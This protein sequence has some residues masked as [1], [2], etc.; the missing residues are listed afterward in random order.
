MM[1]IYV[2]ANENIKYRQVVS[3]SMKNRVEWVDI[4]KFLGMFFVYLWHCGS[5]TGYIYPWIYCFGV[6]L[7]FFLAGCTETYNNRGVMQ[8]FVHMLKA[9][10]IPYLFFSFLDIVFYIVAYGVHN[11]PGWTLEILRG[12]VRNQIFFGWARWFLSGLFVV[13]ILFSLIKLLKNKLVIFLVCLSIFFVTRFY[14]LPD[15]TLARLA[16]NLDSACLYLVYFCM[17]WLLYEP[18]NKLF[19]YVK[20]WPRAILFLATGTYS[21]VLFLGKNPLEILTASTVFLSKLAGLLTAMILVLFV[22]C[23]SYYLSLVDYGKHM[24]SIGRSSLY[25]CGNEDIV[26][27]LTPMV[28]AIFGL[29]EDISSP[30]QAYFMMFA[31]MIIVHK[32]FVPLE[33]PVLRKLQGIFGEAVDKLFSKEKAKL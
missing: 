6:E 22:V 21:A 14:I 24:A 30:M 10:I 19:A 11:I 2:I 27:A 32:V 28:L 15:V 29:T 13:S 33:K 3:K 17:G 18:L 26:K 31:F 9:V 25:L 8:N 16:W 5:V 7:F 1:P 4:S 20:R 23:L 12:S